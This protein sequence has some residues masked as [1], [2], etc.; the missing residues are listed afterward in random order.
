MTA[1]Y[2]SR[3][4]KTSFSIISSDGF[5]AWNDARSTDHSKSLSRSLRG[6]FFYVA[7]VIG[8]LIRVGIS[9]TPKQGSALRFDS[10]LA[11]ILVISCKYTVLV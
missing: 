1:S 6:Y 7:A 10:L 11:R 5:T 4:L 3:R 2:L 9:L 8:W